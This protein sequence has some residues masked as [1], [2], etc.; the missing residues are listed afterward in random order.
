MKNIKVLILTAAL[1]VSIASCKD[2]GSDKLPRDAYSQNPEGIIMKSSPDVKSQM[3]AVIP[4]AEKVTLTE[5]SGQTNSSS[6]VSADKTSWYKTQW[7]GKSGWIQSSSVGGV[8]TVSEQIKISFGE[9]KSNFTADFIK[10][11]ESM[12]VQITAKYS[13]PGGEMEP[14]KIFFLSN[15]TMVVNSKIFSENYSN[16][17]FHYEFLNDGKLLKIRFI[18]SRLNFNEYADMENTSASVFKIDKNDNAI[19]YQIKDNGFFFFNWGF[20]KE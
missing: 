3:I 13:Y 4:F 19:I 1:L 9:Q 11:F 16:T 5:N 2:K 17:F 15:G 20:V 10:A 8:E 12:P 7:N 18:D 6:A 14:A